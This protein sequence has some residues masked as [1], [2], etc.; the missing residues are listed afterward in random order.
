MKRARSTAETDLPKITHSGSFWPDK[1]SGQESYVP[2]DR[3]NHINA[4]HNGS[5]VNFQ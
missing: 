5:L 2:I 1:A 3:G 4:K